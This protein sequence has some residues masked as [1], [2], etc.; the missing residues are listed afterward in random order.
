MSLIFHISVHEAQ[1][2]AYATLD[3]LSLQE[4]CAA[5]IWEG[6]D[7]DRATRFMIP[8]PRRWVAIAAIPD[9][10]SDFRTLSNDAL[11]SWWLEQVAPRHPLGLPLDA[12]VAVLHSIQVDAALEEEFNVW[13]STEHIPMLAT[14][15][16]MLSARR[17]RPLQPRSR[18]VALYHLQ[19]A[20]VY[21]SP[22]WLAVNETPWTRRMRPRFIRPRS[23]M[24]DRLCG[25]STLPRQ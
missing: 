3:S 18:Y 14:I 13:Y 23:F 24:F 5:Q 16:G 8:E 25:R 10:P 6:G 2:A 1:S 21:R 4:P 15:P 9:P 22:Q 19:S 20:S 11:G 7:L 17:F 12:A